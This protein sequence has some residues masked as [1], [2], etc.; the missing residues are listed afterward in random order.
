M[1]LVAAITAG[2]AV[3]LVMWSLDVKALDAFL[4][5]T[6]IVL[7]AILVRTLAPTLPGNRAS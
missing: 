1:G 6:V 2:L 3:W 5:T 4:V 7:V